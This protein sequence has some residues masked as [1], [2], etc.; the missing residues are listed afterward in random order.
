M[1]SKV[2]AVWY[3]YELVVTRLEDDSNS[4]GSIASYVFV[5]GLLASWLLL[6]LKTENVI[7][8]VSAWSL[9][10]VSLLGRCFEPIIS[11]KSVVDQ[12]DTLLL[13]K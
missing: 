13:L 10:N 3:G 9:V 1:D 6:L 2:F 7:C 12:R 8:G 11:V 4:K 5:P